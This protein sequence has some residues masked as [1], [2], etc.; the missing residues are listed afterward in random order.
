MRGEPADVRDDVH[1]LGV[2]WY[3]LIV[4]DVG[5]TPTGRD[6]IAELKKGGV[7]E[8]C[9]KLISACVNPRANSPVRVL[10]DG[11]FTR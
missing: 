2:I 11:A 9:I 8:S 1:A 3:Q 10:G 7:A 5:A 6:W 4:A